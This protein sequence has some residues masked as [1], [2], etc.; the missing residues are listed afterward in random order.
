MN[1]RKPRTAPLGELVTTAFDQ[2]ATYSRDPKEITR[3]AT[4]AI[5]HLLAALQH[6][7]PATAAVK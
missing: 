5:T 6:P 2:A 4:Q 1:E 3:L 7:A